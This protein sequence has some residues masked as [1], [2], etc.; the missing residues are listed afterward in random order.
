MPFKPHGHKK[1]CFCVCENEKSMF[2]LNVDYKHKHF[3]LVDH[4]ISDISLKRN[5]N[6]IN[7]KKNHLL[8]MLI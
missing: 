4:C 1:V 8:K 5:S 7:Q 3:V 6:K 2:N